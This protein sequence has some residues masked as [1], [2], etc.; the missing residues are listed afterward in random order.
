MAVAHLSEHSMK[1]MIVAAVRSALEAEKDR[2]QKGRGARKR[3]TR[4]R[5]P[6][7]K[8]TAGLTVRRMTTITAIAEIV[9]S[10]THLTLV[11]IRDVQLREIVWGEPDC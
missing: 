2:L 5:K 10:C 9:R 11:S 8:A 7:A 6:H 4:S 1:V 3:W